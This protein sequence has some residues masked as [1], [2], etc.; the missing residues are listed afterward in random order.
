MRHIWITFIAS[1]LLLLL[2]EGFF[3]IWVSYGS[4]ATLMNQ[5]G[6]QRTREQRMAKDI[7][8]LV[9]RPAEEHAQALSELQSGLPAWERGQTGLRVGDA[10]IGLPAHPSENIAS[11]ILQSQSDY[12]SLDL[13]FR[14]ILVH[15]SP[16]DMLQV[17]IIMEHEN[18]YFLAISRIN[19]L[20][21]Q[22]IDDVFLQ[23]FW[24]Q[25]GLVVVIGILVTITR[26]L[27][28]RATR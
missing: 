4:P 8:I 3:T 17:Q 23:L 20:W 7:L 6:L 18:G 10:S 27:A 2:L 15:H 21:Q 1:L 13:A 14:A 19:V 9:Y 26:W 5:I 28:Q 16:V 22:Q 11:L 24:I 25:T 12:T